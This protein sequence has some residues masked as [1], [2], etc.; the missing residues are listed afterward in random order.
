ME[1][2]PQPTDGKRMKR[3]ILIIIAASV[4]LLA[5]GFALLVLLTPKSEPEPEAPTYHFYPVTTESVFSNAEYLSLDRSVRYCDDPSGYGVT[6]T[7]DE[8]HPETLLPALR[9]LTRYLRAVIAADETEYNACFTPECLSDGKVPL[10]FSQQMLYDMLITPVSSQTGKDG[11]TLV[12]YRLDYK[13]H[14][15]NGTFR[16]DVESDAVRPHYVVVTAFPDGSV[17][18]SQSSFGSK[19]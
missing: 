4:L 9:L 17:L 16:R 11:N 12:L 14:R 1:K 15:N 6:E 19:P 2:A 13:I 3:K 7:I 10:R 18:I 5:V 8:E